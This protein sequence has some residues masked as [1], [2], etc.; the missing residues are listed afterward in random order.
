M[1]GGAF[2]AQGCVKKGVF[3]T[4]RLGRDASPYPFR[5]K[6]GGVGRI[7]PDEPHSDCGNGGELLV[8]YKIVSLRIKRNNYVACIQI[9][10]P[11]V[12]RPK[13]I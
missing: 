2:H 7:V 10:G 5:E 11:L 4:V 13:N 8:R 9:I 1:D 6:A 3:R 12:G